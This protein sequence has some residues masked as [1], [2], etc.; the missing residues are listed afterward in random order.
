MYLKLRLEAAGRLA[1]QVSR[2]AGSCHPWHDQVTELVGRKLSQRASENPAAAAGRFDASKPTRSSVG[3]LAFWKCEKLQPQATASSSPNQ[4][5]KQRLQ[6]LGDRIRGIAG[7]GAVADLFEHLPSDGMSGAG[8]LQ[9]WKCT[10]KFDGC[11]AQHR[12]AA[13]QDIS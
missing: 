4:G 7:Q 2:K 12:N 11:Q 3:I 13:R 10:G 1:T 9:R 6:V 8:S 5:T